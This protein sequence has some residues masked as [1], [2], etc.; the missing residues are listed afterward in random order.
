MH[1]ILKIKNSVTKYFVGQVLAFTI[2]VNYIINR[3]YNGLFY[4]S[5]HMFILKDLYVH[6]CCALVG[7]QT[8]LMNI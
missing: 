6:S 5:T 4:M 1:K 3:I 7:I 2:F 8:L